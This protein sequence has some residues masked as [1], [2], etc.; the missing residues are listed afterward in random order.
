MQKIWAAALLAVIFV[1]VCA[2]SAM[3]A[4]PELSLSPSPVSFEKTT[5]GEES[6]VV[7]IDVENRGDAGGSIDT[8]AI[9]G[10]DAND[11]K[12]NGGDCGWIE[13]GGHCTVWV[14]FAPGSV[15][16]KTAI[17][18]VR[19]KE[20]PEAT[21][22]LVAS[23]V[24]PQLAFGPASLDFGI[25]R[26]NQ[27]SS[28]GLQV[29]NGGEAGTRIG[30]VGI[31]GKDTGNFWIGSSD[32][33]NGRWLA[34]GESCWIQVNFNAWQATG[35]EATL[36]VDADNAPFSAELRGTGGE[37]MLMSEINPVEFGT[38]AIGG[39]GTVQTIHLSNEGNIAGGYFIA[40]IAGGDVASFE[41]I[42]ENCTGEE[43][44]PGANCLAH[45]RFDP[46]GLGPKVARLAMFGDSNGGTMVFLRG[47]GEPATAT[48]ESHGGLSP[49]W[50]A[51]R[52]GGR[53]VRGTALRA[54]VRCKRVK[55][56][57]L[58]EVR[59]GR[60]AR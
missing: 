22:S 27:G 4:G 38:A 3:A 21:V 8:T 32:C 25:V 51:A 6:S 11:F 43:I 46:V 50:K 40:V 34:P 33:F 1:L 28:Q 30:S 47:E 9:E 15:G 41:L 26:V 7:G 45:V 53:P 23:A 39:E 31:E 49:V 42:D 5:A 35:Y 56:C 48:P 19:V 59:H 44:A 60:V 17:L 24:V 29:T 36:T 18:A 10:T 52:K 54:P 20:A 57:N 13:P 58:A 12:F 55:V 37:A 14:K 16:V 2:S